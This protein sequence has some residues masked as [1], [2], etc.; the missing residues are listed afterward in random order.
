LNVPDALLV[1]PLPDTAVGVEKPE[2]EAD[3]D[4]RGLVTSVSVDADIERTGAV[5]GALYPESSLWLC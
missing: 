5:R 2:V 1:E 3:K 4:V